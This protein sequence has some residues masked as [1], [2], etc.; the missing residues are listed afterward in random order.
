MR[1]V[2]CARSGGQGG[3]VVT[4]VVTII[5]AAASA[6]KLVTQRASM[7]RLGEKR[8]EKRVA[9]KIESSVNLIGTPVTCFTESRR[10]SIGA[11]R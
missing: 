6:R 10:K 8:R 1:L 5:A 11:S 3:V 7:S 4:V 2:S 9:G